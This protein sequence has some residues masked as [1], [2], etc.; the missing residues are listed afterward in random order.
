MR[1][2]ITGY[3]VLVITLVLMLSAC[4]GSGGGSDDPDPETSCILGAAAIGECRI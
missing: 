3:R 4:G 1:N 2:A